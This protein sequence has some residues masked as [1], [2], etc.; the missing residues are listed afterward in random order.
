MKFA[1]IYYH[2]QDPNQDF[3]Q[4]DH[5]GDP[6]VHS[7]N[8]WHSFCAATRGKFYSLLESTAFKELN[9]TP[10]DIA[11]FAFTS[12]DFYFLEVYPRLAERLKKKGC[13]VLFSFHENTEILNQITGVHPNYL[14]QIRTLAAYFDAYIN[15]DFPMQNDF[16]KSVTDKPVFNWR[17]CFPKEKMF[18]VPWEKKLGLIL[19]PRLLSRP[20][21]N[22]VQNLSLGISLAEKLKTHL[23]VIDEEDA[24]P[25]IVQASCLRRFRHPLNWYDYLRELSQHKIVINIDHTLSFGR[26]PADSCFS[27]TLCFGGVSE[28][29]R[30]LFPEL[31]Y[32][33]T[34]TKAIERQVLAWYENRQKYELYLSKAR[35]TF[36]RH[37]TYE[38]F[39]HTLGNTLEQL[40]DL[41]STS[42]MNAIAETPSR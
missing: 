8:A 2:P 10:P 13:I 34:D 28:C 27:G 22:F 3:S 32:R 12:P 29:Q 14:G 33:E 19:G 15:V 20:R 38:S 26:V 1:L 5:W 16:W 7:H 37:L 39:R 18:F 25:S 11:L 30:L 4:R 42:P 6:A 23:T 24:C 21:R 40:R 17:Y 36:D 35:A 9:E 31:G 41:A